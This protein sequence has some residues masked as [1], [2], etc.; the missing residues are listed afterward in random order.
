MAVDKF[1]F[2]SPG[3]FVNEIDNSQRPKEAFGEGPLIIGR[4]RRGPAMRPVQIG[5]MSEF[6]EVFGS[7][8]PG[9][10]GGDLWRNGNLAGPT[11]GA[12]AAQA[13]LRNNG[14]ITYVRLLGD[15]HTDATTTG[16]AGWNFANS[17]SRTL[18]SNA[19]AF[20]LFVMASSSNSVYGRGGQGTGKEV[21]GTLGAIFYVKSGAVRLSGSVVAEKEGLHATASA[22]ILVES[23]ANGDFKVE[24]IGSAGA[25]EETARVNFSNTSENFIRRAMNTNPTRTNNT[26]TSTDGLKTYWVGESFEKFVSDN[27]KTT[28]KWGYIAAIVDRDADGGVEGAD[29]QQG[30]ARAKTGW[31]FAQ[32]LGEYSSF[33]AQNQQKLFYF[34]ALDSGEWEQSHIKISITRIKAPGNPTINPYGTFDVEVRDIRDNDGARSVI[35][36]FSNCNLNPYSPNYIARKIGDKYISWSDTDRRYREYGNYPNL[37]RYIRVK[38]S[39]DVDRGV[40]NPESLPFGVYGPTRFASFSIVSGTHGIVA[41]GGDGGHLGPNTQNTTEVTSQFFDT[42]KQ[43]FNNDGASSGEGEELG[44]GGNWAPIFNISASMVYPRLTLRTDSADTALGSPEDAYF[45]VDT[46]ESTAAAR[47]DRSVID[48]VRAHPAEIGKAGDVSLGTDP[49]TEFSFVFTLDDL[50][51]SGSGTTSTYA[52][53]S[54][55]SHQNNLSFTAVRGTYKEVLDNGYDS[56]TTVLAGGFDGLDVQEKEPF[57]NHVLSEN[58]GELSNYAYY[59]IKKAIDAVSDPEVVEYN[60]AT[61]PGVRLPALTNHLLTTVEGRGDALAIIDIENDY[62]PNTESTSAA[63]DRGGNVDNAINS[64]RNRALDTSYGC[65]FYPWVQIRDTLEGGL[66][67]VP[68]SVAALGAMS[69][70]ERTSELWVAPAGFTRGGLSRGAAGLPVVAVNQHLT[71]KQRDKL[72]DVH[73]NPIASFPAE[74]IVIFGQKTLQITP[75]A[76]DRINVR[77]MLI[78][79]K[80]TISRMAATLLFDQNVKSTWGRF[81]GRVNPFLGSV[82]ARLGLADFKVVLDDTTTTPDLVDR[83]IM[84]A[85]VYLKPAKAIEFIALDFVVTDQGAS[86]A[87]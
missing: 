21:T 26:V 78:F 14:P 55:G 73:V 83:N 35:E 82:K 19:G 12:Y 29:F 77:R 27:V 1:K 31:Y 51:A 18:S 40:I 16:K 41:A 13:W 9:G 50:Q 54:S 53:W 44:G 63:S 32:N 72:Y 4:A 6:I 11:Y 70:S 33:D 80:K 75:S 69:F 39:G 46:R 38:M 2:V 85:K 81:L 47:F 66:V 57:G 56:F 79:V 23:D 10:Q 58:Q 48:L 62:T 8:V 45:G 22:G 59:S 64:L 24:V 25:T 7:P 71:S 17:P 42:K 28:K 15:Q 5:S 67:W 30:S 74:G 36:R 76:L 52:E 37:S 65:A 34:E 20:G 61:M 68:P 60:L 86:F 87:D 49:K 3:V 84:Y 43:P